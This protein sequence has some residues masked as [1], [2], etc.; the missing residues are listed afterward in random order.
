M[1][2]LS[3]EKVQE[4]AQ[5]F[6]NNEV[7]DFINLF[8]G[9]DRTALALDLENHKSQDPS[10]STREQFVIELLLDRCF[11]FAVERRQGGDD[12]ADQD[13]LRALVEFNAGD[14]VINSTFTE[15]Q[16]TLG[17][18]LDRHEAVM[19]FEYGEDDDTLTREQIALLSGLAVE[20]VRLAGF[21]EGEDKLPQER[22][23]VAR[24]ADVQRWLL[25]KGKYR[26]FKWLPTFVLKPEAPS[27]SARELAETIHH[28]A[29]R[30][31]DKTSEVY[32]L[33]PIEHRPGFEAYLKAKAFDPE[34]LQWV[35]PENAET[36]GIALMI[37]PCWLFE[38]LDFWASEARRRYMVGQ[39]SEQMARKSPPK[40]PSG[41]VADKETL[42]EVLTNH[43]SIEKHPAQ[44]KPNAKIDGY[45]VIGGIA[46]AHQHEGKTQFLWVPD[47]VAVPDTSIVKYFPAVGSDE[48]TTRHSGLAK[49]PELGRAGINKI[50]VKD[51]DSFNEILNLLVTQ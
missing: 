16:E 35:T 23:G 15:R 7:S 42:R 37:D 46:F 43:P 20:T 2:N 6:I 11:D 21:A 12:Q 32:S 34:N 13:S 31:L 41:V 33:L 39:L 24:K 45:R 10:G 28:Q 50:K 4:I 47:E 18:L 44:R 36:L 27:P 5:D 25:H 14:T 29:L 51:S 49:F 38:S 17:L 30:Q 1:E 9:Q 19:A 26:E 3:R 48:P 8:L 22:P 40:A